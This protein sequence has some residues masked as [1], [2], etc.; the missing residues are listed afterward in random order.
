MNL[1]IYPFQYATTDINDYGKYIGNS[2]N[3]TPRK[4]ITSFFPE[5]I[6]PYFADVN[7][8][9]RA[10]RGNTYAFEAYLEFTIENIDTYKE[11]VSSVTAGLEGTPFPYDSSY[12]E[13]SIGSLIL[14]DDDTFQVG[15]TTHIGFRAADVRMILCSEENAKKFNFNKAV[16]PGIQGGPLM[17]VIAAK[18]VCFKEA[19]DPAFKK[20]QQGVI[21][22]AQALCKGLMDRDIKIVSD[23][24]NHATT[25]DLMLGSLSKMVL[26]ALQAIN[27][28]PPAVGTLTVT[29]GTPVILLSY[30]CR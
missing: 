22:N 7:Y 26:S 2:Y 18:A 15:E 13:Y 11:Y 29:R 21:D 19:L 30:G 16:F 14:P 17:H 3:K 9:Y 20:Y 4:V 24:T 28:F 10:E 12:I 6:E 8:S 27:V 25:F 5:K 23:G 1:L